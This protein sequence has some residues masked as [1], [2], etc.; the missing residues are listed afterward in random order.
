LYIV[1][2]KVDETLPWIELKGEYETRREARKRAEECL[3]SMKTKIMKIPEKK[4]L[5]KPMAYVK[6][7]R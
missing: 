1:W 2:I 4:K 3:I 5:M 7:S 6:A